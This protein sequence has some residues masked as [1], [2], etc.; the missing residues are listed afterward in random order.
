MKN[1]LPTMFVSLALLPTSVHS[2]DY[3][4]GQYS[5]WFDAERAELVTHLQAE[6]QEGGLSETDAK[7][8][9]NQ[10][11]DYLAQCF[12]ETGED[13]VGADRFEFETVRVRMGGESY[14]FPAHPC[15]Y[16]FVERA[17]VSLE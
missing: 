2:S 1:L 15:V 7:A 4:K 5:A 10:S 13:V 6:L 16:E 14:G 11:V 12:A 3:A 9:A 17:G 8:Q